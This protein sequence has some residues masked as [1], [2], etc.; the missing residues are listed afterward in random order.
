MSVDTMSVIP[1]IRAH[2]KAR[3]VTELE[4]LSRLEAAKALRICTRSVDKL[5]RSGALGAVRLGRR[6]VIP[7]RNIRRL[8]G[9]E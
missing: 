4:F 1:V 2:G 7:V 3:R 9:A 8:A 5:I 6:V